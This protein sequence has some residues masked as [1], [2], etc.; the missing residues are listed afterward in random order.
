MV[1]EITLPERSD[2]QTQ[3]T[4]NAPSV[5][6]SDEAWEQAYEALLE[7]LP[8]IEAY[9]GHL[10][11]S[12]S[13]LADAL[14]TFNDFTAQVGK[15]QVYAT[16]S[17]SVDTTN[18][19]AAGRYSQAQGLYSRA[20][21]AMSFL[22]PELL[23]IGQE[24]LKQWLEDEPRLAIYKHYVE[25]LLRKREH[26]RSPDVEE[27]L[28]MLVDPFR[29]VSGTAGMLTNADFK[30]KPAVTS[31]DVELPVSSGTVAKILSSSDREARRTA[32]ESYT[33]EY[34]A[35]KNT[36]ANNLAT[37]IKQSV[38]KMRARRH[39]STLEAALYDYNIPIEVFHNL[40]ATFKKN[41][42]TWHRYW[43]IRKKALGVEELYLYDVWA[44]LTE[45]PPSIPYEQAVD[46]ICEGLAPMGEEYVG[47]VRNGCLRDRWIDVYPNEGKRAGAFSL[48]SSDTFPFILM[49]YS[50]NMLGLSTLAHELGHSM[51]ALLAWENQPALYM[52]YSSF[53]A[54]VASNFHQA[55]V[56]AYLLETNP[57]PNF[58]ISVIEEAMA[59][60]HRYFLIMPTLA[61]FELEMH[62][63]VER[64]EGLTA[65]GMTERLADLF[66]EAYGPEMQIDRDRVGIRW[67]TFGHLYIDY[68]VFQYA[69]GLSGAHALAKRILDGEEGAVDDHINFL[70]VGGSV[71]PL[72]ALIAAGVDLT[73]PDAVVETF[74]VLAGMVD[75]LEELLT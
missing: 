27:L 64:G 38:F 40:I 26:V 8:E 14:E 49:S 55:M 63:A 25:N 69:T 6:A 22:D 36:L 15:V 65:D 68:Y 39:S 52:N 29:G 18:Q 50:D 56:R 20:L 19:E 12:S 51:H 54:E 59:N 45:K 11:D 1:T 71:Y 35:H 72:D 3:Y 31:E 5:F 43:A 2:V 28:G 41:L 23:T 9:K 70:K 74:D 10:G 47:M 32:S 60:F 37:S 34:L 30:F 73:K 7:R 67:A 13:T 21:A 17:H 24:T 16:M 4:W 33:D 46:W 62:E 61:R 53:V 66:T 42:P 58:Q 44:P 75:R 48:R 57:D